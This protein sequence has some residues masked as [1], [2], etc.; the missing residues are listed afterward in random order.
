MK[1]LAAVFVIAVMVP[2]IGLAWLATRSLR[3]QEIVV[4]SQRAL[5]HQGATDALANDFNI[6]LDD[7]RS[8]YGV[9][10]E[11][12]INEVGPEE[13]AEN[14]NQILRSRWSQAGVGA[15][16]SDEGDWMSPTVTSTDPEVRRFLRDTQAFLLNSAPSEFY[17]APAT[18]G[19]VVTVQEW[20]ASEWFDSPSNPFTKLKEKTASDTEATSKASLVAVDR[21]GN[22]PFDGAMAGGGVTVPENSL[23]KSAPSL[24]PG[25]PPGTAAPASTAPLDLTASPHPSSATET[26]SPERKEEGDAALYEDVIIQQQKV[27][28]SEDRYRNRTN[29][30]RQSP[31]DLSLQQAEFAADEDGPSPKR[32]RASSPRPQVGAS[33]APSQAKAPP[34]FGSSPDDS[35]SQ[36]AEAAQIGSASP[37]GQF[38]SLSS[39]SRTRNVTPLGQ[40]NQLQEGGQYFRLAQA[41]NDALADNPNYLSRSKLD[42]NTGQL[43]EI[44]AGRPEGAISRFVSGGLQILLWRRDPTAPGMVFWVQLD[45]E[46]IKGELTAIIRETAE[47]MGNSEA[48]LALLDASGKVVSQTREGFETDWRHPFVATE[49]GEILPHWEVAAYLVDPRA[50]ARS[51]RSARLTLWL[52]VPIL[53]A[54]ISVGGLLIIRDIGREMHLARQK[55]DFVSNVSH[56]LKTPLT[57]IRMFS[58]LIG[59]RSDLQDTKRLEYSGIISREAAR[60][61]RLINNLLD[62]SRMERGEKRY[63]AERFA[64][65]EFVAET[66]DNYRHQIES[67]GFQLHFRNLPEDEGPAEIRGDRDALAQVLVNLLSNA[68]KYG[69]ETREIDVEVDRRDGNVE[70]AVLD[71]GPGVNRK[72]ATRIF[73]KFYRVDDSLSSGIEG[74]GLGLTLARQIARAHGGDVEYRNRSGGGSQF[75]LRLPL[76]ASVTIDND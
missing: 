73:E 33:D 7:V 6:F 11:R 34:A 37:R 10:L 20:S 71:R 70:I 49:V 1:K 13:L 18:A 54:A 53:L 5:L 16:V 8:F 35:T 32:G 75:S 38:D 42:V 68:E 24:A 4:H 26:A 44:M 22:E 74:S 46:E 39:I 30:L 48:S 40:L 64:I 41:A 14:Y 29:L 58:D 76:L 19:N 51:A 65:R 69:G 31:N 43:R 3:D 47:T 9:L 67:D 36:G 25:A 50:V 15:A 60:L 56:E 66:I 72:N 17:L 28:I 57:S 52:L 55:T 62:F 27:A 12:L 63:R 21:L 45:V 59:K 23:S 2:A 61:S